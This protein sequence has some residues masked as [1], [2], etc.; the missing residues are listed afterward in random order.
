MAKISE[1]QCDISKVCTIISFLFAV[2]FLGY[3]FEYLL[4]TIFLNEQ[5]AH[6]FISTDDNNREVHTMQLPAEMVHLK[7]YPYGSNYEVS[8]YEKMRKDALLSGNLCRW[9]NNI[10]ETYAF[11]GT[12]MIH[13]AMTHG[14]I[15]TVPSSLGHPRI[16]K[17]TPEGKTRLFVKNES[18]GTQK[19]LYGLEM[20]EAVGRLHAYPD[21][22]IVHNK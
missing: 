16:Y 14:T 19:L 13:E 6:I 20:A 22:A 17:M 5:H 8:D 2:G 3:Q 4:K 7:S 15:K 1:W 11:C 21:G 9:R 12:A 18:N 10:V